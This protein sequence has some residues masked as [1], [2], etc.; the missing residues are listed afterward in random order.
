MCKSAVEKAPGRR[1]ESEH[2]LFVRYT[3]ISYTPF[4]FVEENKDQCLPI[5]Y[6]RTEQQ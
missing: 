1:H 5:K 4:H 6:A 2:S 3:D